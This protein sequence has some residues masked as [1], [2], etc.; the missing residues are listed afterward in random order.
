MGR[1]GFFIALGMCAALLAAAGLIWTLAHRPGADWT[2]S[3]NR[4]LETAA[5]LVLALAVF[6]GVC[7]F[8]LYEWTFLGA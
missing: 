1:L 8:A 5:Q 3:G 7:A 2:A 4:R 6:A